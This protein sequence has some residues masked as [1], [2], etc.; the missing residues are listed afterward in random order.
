MPVGRRL[1]NQKVFG[2]ESSRA[3]STGEI[4]FALRHAKS[5]REA[6]RAG[7]T[8]EQSIEGVSLYAQ[9]ESFQGCNGRSHSRC[10][11]LRNEDLIVVAVSTS[12]VQN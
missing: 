10:S 7:F 6:E 5:H 2:F 1:N 11:I 9:E 3:L 4:T 12:D 8:V